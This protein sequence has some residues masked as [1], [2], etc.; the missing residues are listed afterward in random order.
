M[1]Q[2]GVTEEEGNKP[3]R[4]D[5]LFVKYVQ[6]K[7]VNI[8]SQTAL[9]FFGTEDGYMDPTAASLNEKHRFEHEYK[10]AQKTVGNIWC[11]DK[12]K[13]YDWVFA[14]IVTKTIKNPVLFK[15]VEACASQL[16]QRLRKDKFRFVGVEFPQGWSNE[17][18]FFE[19]IITVFRASLW[20]SLELWACFPTA[21]VDFFK[22]VKDKNGKEKESTSAK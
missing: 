14:L 6:M 1:F 8:E 7:L 18:L 19:K 22:M 12:S 17:K 15:N 20:K 9:L 10:N 11:Y 3:D 16:S 5:T 13:S 21:E 4:K 2:E